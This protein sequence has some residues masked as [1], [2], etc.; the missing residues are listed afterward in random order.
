MA[1]SIITAFSSNTNAWFSIEPYFF[2]QLPQQ[3]FHARM[4][5]TIRIQSREQDYE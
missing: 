1:P 5:H 3:N 4:G 2:A